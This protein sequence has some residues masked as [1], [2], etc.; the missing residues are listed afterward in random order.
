MSFKIIKKVILLFL[1]KMTFYEEDFC[2]CHV[3]NST[4]PDLFLED[5]EET[6]NNREDDDDA[7]T[8]FEDE[9]FYFKGATKR[10]QIMLKGRPFHISKINFKEAKRVVGRIVGRNGQ[11]LATKG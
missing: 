7:S 11:I 4:T 8:L 3:C 6:R 9:M 1:D 10:Q 2:N 5:Y